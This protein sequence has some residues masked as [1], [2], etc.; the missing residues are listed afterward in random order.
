MPRLFLPL[1]LDDLMTLHQKAGGLKLYPQGKTN[2]EGS[3]IARD[4]HTPYCG[5]DLHANQ[6]F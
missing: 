2:K 4:K 1:S 3:D 6:L 5:K